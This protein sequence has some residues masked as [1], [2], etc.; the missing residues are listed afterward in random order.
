MAAKNVKAAHLDNVEIVEGDVLRAE[1]SYDIV[2]LDLQVSP[3]HVAHAYEVLR[4][5]GFLAC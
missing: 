3:E 5:G 1:G 4:P 2:H